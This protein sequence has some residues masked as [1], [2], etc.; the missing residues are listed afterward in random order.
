SHFLSRELERRWYRD[1]DRTI[2]LIV[3]ENRS[4]EQGAIIHAQVAA[5]VQYATYFTAKPPTAASR[6]ITAGEIEKWWHS[7]ALALRN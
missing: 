1:Q 6:L 4:S 3:T 7:P 2:S 5:A